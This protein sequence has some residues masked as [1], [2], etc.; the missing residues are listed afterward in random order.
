MEH[1]HGPEAAMTDRPARAIES[2][3]QR[4]NSLNNTA[5]NIQHRLGMCVVRLVHGEPDNAPKLHVA[6]TLSEQ[7]RESGPELSV[8]TSQIDRLEH[9]LSLALDALVTLETV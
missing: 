1:G 6:G 9:Q 3:I 4:L 7:P 8:L 5:D 2:A